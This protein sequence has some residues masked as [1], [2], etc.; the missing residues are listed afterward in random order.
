MV[1]K[2]RINEDN[3]RE[4]FIMTR[5]ELFDHYDD[6]VQD[7]FSYITKRMKEENYSS[8]RRSAFIKDVFKKR[9]DHIVDFMNIVDKYV[10]FI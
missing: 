1:R 8:A 10:D 6:R 5:D 9:P 3:G 4:K 7:F 2:I